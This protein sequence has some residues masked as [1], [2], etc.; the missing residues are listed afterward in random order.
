MDP[1][2][3][4][5]KHGGSIILRFSISSA[6][7][8]GYMNKAKDQCMFGRKPSTFW[9]GNELSKDGKVWSPDPNPINIL[10]NDLKKAVI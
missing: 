10:W 8:R 5:Q 1:T 6:Q 3:L 2:Q 9:H 7:E 4:V